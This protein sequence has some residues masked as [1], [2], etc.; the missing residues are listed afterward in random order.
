MTDAVFPHPTFPH[1]THE[2]QAG[3]AG[4]L[5]VPE[6]L[7]HPPS[8]ISPEARE[9]LGMRQPPPNFPDPK[10]I[11]AWRQLVARLDDAVAS[12]LNALTNSVQATVEDVRIAGVLCFTAR[13]TTVRARGEDKVCLDLHGGGLYQGGGALARALTGLFADVRRIRTI[14]VDYRMP[15]D[16]PYPGGL[17]DCVAVYRALLDHT[18]PKNVIVSGASAGGNLATAMILRARDEGLPQPSGVLLTS[19]EVDL[20]ESGDTFSTLDGIDVLGSLLPVNRLYAAGHDLTDPLLSPLFGDF[21]AGFPPTYLQSGTRDLYLSN[22][23]RMHRALRNA[24]VRVECFV[25][26]ARPHLGF[27]GRAPEDLET[28]QEADRF[29]ESIL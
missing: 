28:I 26:E 12:S 1:R 22:T 13:P 27:G 14:G 16:H 3:T 24:G 29:I 8:S 7:V 10:D 18:D 15:P 4:V 20:T 2:S 6:R 5:R 9:A 23:V 11:A 17:D 25:F 19:P 21:T